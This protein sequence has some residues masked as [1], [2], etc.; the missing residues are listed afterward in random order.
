[1]FERSQKFWRIVRQIPGRIY[2]KIPMIMWGVTTEGVV[3]K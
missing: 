3:F 2:S 1:M